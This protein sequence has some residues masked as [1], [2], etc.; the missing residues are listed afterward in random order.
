VP[1]TDEFVATPFSTEERL[2]AALADRYALERE[3]GRGGMATVFLAR[4]LKHGRAV[5][6]KVLRPE[7]TSTVGAERFLR[8]I[9]IAAQLTHAH[10]L[11]VHDSG[12]VDGLLYFVM[13]YVEGESLRQRLDRERQLP[14]DV[15]LDI[16]REVAEALAYAH[17]RGVVHRDIKPENILLAHGHAL[18][19][20]FGIARALGPGTAA[21][22]ERL[23]TAGM[24]IGTPA[25]MSPEQGAGER[26]VDGRSD[27]YSLA[28]V[29][30]EMLAGAP[31]FGG[32]TA[33]MV[34]ARHLADPPPPIR[35][36]RPS[37][38]ERVE[39]ALRR[40]LEKV[41]A[42]RYAGAG[43]FARALAPRASRATVGVAGAAGGQRRL[44]LLVAAGIILLAAI[45]GPHIA[46]RL[47]GPPP[48]DHSLFV[49]LPF[50]HRDGAA[51]AMLSGDQCER[52]LHS[53]L[54]YWRDLR[55][56]SPLRVGDL[57]ARDERPVS[58]ARALAQA[59]AL[60]AGR[61]AWGDVWEVGDS[62]YVHAAL[63]DVAR[64]AEL[65]EHTIRFP[66]HGAKPAAAFDSLA[67]ILL[68]RRADA[69]ASGARHTQSLAAWQALDR[70]QEA[71]SQWDLERADTAFRA[72][73]GF[74]PGF[75][76]AH[77]WLARVRSWMGD[78]PLSELN[79]TIARAR[80]GRDRLAP[81]DRVLAD[82]LAAL[83][84]GEFA[85]ACRLYDS[86]VAGDAN[87]FEAWFGLGECRRRDPIVERDP[88]SPSGWR[89]RSSHEAAVRAYV[90]AIELVPSFQRA[91][92][93]AAF[94]RLPAL[95]AADFD[96]VRQ[97]MALEPDTAWFLAEP[98]L[99][100]DTLVFH[101][102]P[103]EEVLRDR[104]E[105]RSPTALRAVERNRDRLRALI[106][107]WRSAFPSSAD[108]HE[109]LALLL[110]SGGEMAGGE[111]E[112]SA[113]AALAAARR[114]TTDPAQALRL[115]VA[116]VRLRLKGEDFDGARAGADSVLA[117][118]PRPAAADA[119]TLAGLAALTGRARRAAEL[120]RIGAP[121]DTV[122]AWDGAPTLVPPPAEE[123]AL[124]LRAFAALGAPRDSI[125]ALERQV[126]QM[127]ARWVERPSQDRVRDALLYVPMAL[128]FPTV[129]VRPVHEA[130]AADFALL[131]A[132]LA[133]ARGDTAAVRAVVRGWDEAVR[134]ARPGDY[135]ADGSFQA[136]WLLL[137]LGDSA[138][139]ARQLD[140]TL[141]AL[142]S[143]TPLLLRRVPQAAA[144]P[145]LMSLRAELA[146]R[147][148]DA[149]TAARWARG[150][151]A[152]WA[153]ADPELRPLVERARAIAGGGRR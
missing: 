98:G 2:R 5:A 101:P 24:S 34:I 119:L 148:G 30:Y 86:L 39:R 32:A 22:P 106:T 50:Q 110:E 140:L 138:G 129:G 125:L 42:D 18:V 63:Y 76:Q 12:E 109:A 26:E 135:A 108:A 69:S 43:E 64:G 74:D 77:L 15:A 21:G 147:G 37:V 124:A 79:A 51:P 66:R 122:F 136:A 9:R 91:F 134:A 92:R 88:R 111:A 78:V 68:S 11:T 153:D 6:V 46:S 58:T 7:L 112:R 8:E 133:L 25:Y 115:A 96:V 1:D 83:A 152:L 131:R 52:L 53:S 20:D 84:D 35:T 130:R 145:R 102:W 54:S 150:V 29:L 49:V 47:A 94:S 126:A 13:P 143:L 14:V 97:G 95:L 141:E 139:A 45:A 40:A 10:I 89:F 38:P 85:Q 118:H 57:R 67:A 113:T 132:Q 149:A 71:V 36:L 142:P 104:P 87:D 73:I 146:A 103:I 61:L 59:R 62:V 41:P 75:P 65:R 120:A 23:T 81:R 105:T 93:A 3:L 90:R 31:P 48:V 70:G 116:D 99:E 82:A 123:P 28:C 117:A 72:A 114:L 19:A 17:G 100:H 33:P 107:A 127:V 121:A 60:G 44:A 56:V 137:A 151:A 144:L 80:A 27:I 4:D 128:A 16:A 55:L